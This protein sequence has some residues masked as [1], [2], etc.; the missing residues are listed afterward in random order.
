MKWNEQLIDL[1]KRERQTA[2]Q[3]IRGHGL[4]V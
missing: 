1:L 4:F 3:K 2:R